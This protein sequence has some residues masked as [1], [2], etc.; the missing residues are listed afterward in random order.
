MSAF[1]AAVNIKNRAVNP[2]NP[3]PT[4]ESPS[5]APPLNATFNAEGIPP[6]STASDVRP[7]DLVAISIPTNPVKALNKAPN[8]KH[9]ELCQPTPSAPFNAGIAPKIA[10][11]TAIERT[12]INI[13]LYSLLR[14]VIAPLL[15]YPEI[16]STF[17]FLI[18]ILPIL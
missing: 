12:K 9:R 2:N 11:T 10:S 6:S 14:N 13:I 17:L 18:L 15:I 3:N 8:K 5:T 1:E 4:T 7:L 16:S